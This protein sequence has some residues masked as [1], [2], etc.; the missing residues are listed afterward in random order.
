MVTTDLPELALR[1][2]DV[3]WNRERWERLPEDGNRYEVIDGVLYMTTAPSAFHQW[4]IRQI[5]FTLAPVID[6]AGVG[7][8]LWSPI[9][10]F[11]PGCDPVQPD[12]I[13]IRTENLNIIHDRRIAGIPALLVEVL[14]PSNPTQDT[15]TKRKAY[16]RAGVPE[17]WIVRPAGRDLLFCTQPD[18][19]LRD[20]AGSDLIAPDDTLVSP[21]L[22]VRT[23]I[24]RF[25]ADAPDTTW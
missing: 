14:S 17:Y 19:A 21:T 10:L 20:Y 8:T 3:G 22:P 18:A 24:A 6:Q 1:S 7:V 5:V 9:G 2:Q 13:V 12:I 16:A 25:F 11:M 15:E 4:I 23:P